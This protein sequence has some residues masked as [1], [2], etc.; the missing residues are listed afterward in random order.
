MSIY[1]VPIIAAAVLLPV[2]FYRA[3]VLGMRWRDTGWP[4]LTAAV[5]LYL[6]GSVITVV[7][8]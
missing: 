4:G 1:L 5:V 2:G 3:R 6:I 7:A 8:Q